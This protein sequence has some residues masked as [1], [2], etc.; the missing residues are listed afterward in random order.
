MKEKKKRKEA[1]FVKPCYTYHHKFDVVLKSEPVPGSPGGGLLPLHP[2]VSDSGLRW[3][4]R[5][6]NFN[7]LPGD[8]LG[9]DVDGGLEI[10][11]CDPLHCTVWF[12]KQLCHA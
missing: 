1:L 6:C 7:E 10:M 12:S 5:R 9:G 2:S 11:P 3:G 8:A 4:L